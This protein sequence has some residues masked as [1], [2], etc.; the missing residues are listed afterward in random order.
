MLAT[1]IAL[2]LPFTASAKTHRPM[3]ASSGAPQAA[4]ISCPGDVVVWVNTK[5]K[6]YHLQGSSFYGNTKHGR[7]MCKAD[8]DR[9]GDHAAKTAGTGSVNASATTAPA[10]PSKHHHH[11]SSSMMT[12]APAASPM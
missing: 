12:P 5:S 6:A 3:A 9:A 4:M 8:A 1:A 10:G 7:Y 11:K 2:L